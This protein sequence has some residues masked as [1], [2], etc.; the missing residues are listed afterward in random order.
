[1][2]MSSF[3]QTYKRWRRAAVDAVVPHSV[4]VLRGRSRSFRVALTFD[5]GPHEMTRAY[6]DVLDA[7]GARA[8]FF[9]VGRECA[10]RPDDVAEIERRGHELGG[11]GYSHRTF[12]TLA[13]ADLVEEL[14]GT[15]R[16]LPRGRTPRPLVRPPHGVLSVGSLAA[17]AAAGFTTV[18][19][20]LDPEDYRKDIGADEL[21][22]R[23]APER[24][25]AGEI[26]L[27]HEGRTSTIEALPG[28]LGRLRDAGVE[29]VT[30]GD[31]LSPNQATARG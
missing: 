16:L 13:R 11:H 7:Y 17:C 22:T 24:L 12:P 4:L 19:W 21:E 20:S 31:L 26:I 6:L 3:R 30:V 9:L 8:T 25:A 28:I 14:E 27:L 29:V 1:V 5:D 18:L 10:A 2:T 15:R 23:L